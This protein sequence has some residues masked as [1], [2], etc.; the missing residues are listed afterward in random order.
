MTETAQG[1]T[2]ITACCDANGRRV[3]CDN[4][5]QEPARPAC[6][7]SGS[8]AHKCLSQRAATGAAGAEESGSNGTAGGRALEAQVWPDG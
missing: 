3:I 8:D 5:G 1:A 6:H 2:A 4:R 7:S